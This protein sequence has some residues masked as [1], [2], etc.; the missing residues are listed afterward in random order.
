MVTES[1]VLR[2]HNEC[3]CRLDTVPLEPL[4]SNE[5]RCKAKHSAVSAGTEKISYRRKFSPSMHRNPELLQPI[6]YGYCMAAEVIDIG[7][8]VTDYRIGDLVY[9]WQNHKQYF[10][11]VPNGIADPSPGKESWQ[12]SVTKIPTGVTTQEA[13]W[14]TILR[15]ALF[16]AMKA[17]V[18][19]TDTVVVMGLGI[20]GITTVQF[21]KHMG[22]RRIIG[23]DPIP[24]RAE[25]ARKFGATHT[26]AKTAEEI[27]DDVHELTDGK[28]ADSVIDTT[29]GFMGI[30]TGCELARGDGT[31]V[32][33]GDPADADSMIYTDRARRAYTKIIGIWIDM[34]STNGPNP[35]YPTTLDD[36]HDTIFEL[37][38]D[39]R[40]NVRDMTTDIVSPADADTMYKILIEDPRKHLGVVFDWSL[41]GN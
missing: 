31:L 12:Y 11:V 2:F 29:D 39:G 5:I 33:V 16:A 9:V 38:R 7:N 10:N 40:I 25:I 1:K 4:K 6:T 20:F 24:E 14:M 23:V 26:F 3:D 15:C 22:A 27:W 17:E 13:C 35:F 21:L 8:D 32:I 34:M 36:V 41:L 19:V 30:V 18:K 28:M 37:L